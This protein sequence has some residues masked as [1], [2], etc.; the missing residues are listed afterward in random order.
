MNHDF[1]EREPQREAS[2]WM[3][4]GLLLPGNY[5]LG[6]NKD[7]KTIE[8]LVIEATEFKYEVRSDLGFKKPDCLAHRSLEKL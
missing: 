2:Q 4:F 3:V 1:Y 5:Q 7:Q 6:I 8:T